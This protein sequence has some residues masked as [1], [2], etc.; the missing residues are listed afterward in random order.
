[1]CIRDRLD[2]VLDA[3]RPEL[4]LPENLRTSLPAPVGGGPLR[5]D[6][7]MVAIGLLILL[8]ATLSYFFLPDDLAKM[9]DSARSFWANYSRS[10][11]LLYTSRCV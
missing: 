7:V 1:M 5:R 4:V 2:S 11:C 9:R 8:L 10:S 3:K 6:Y